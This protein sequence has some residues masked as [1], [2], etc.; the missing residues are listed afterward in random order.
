MRFE[1]VQLPA[2]LLLIQKKIEKDYPA[3][4]NIPR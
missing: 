2:E 4:P 1:K 3:L